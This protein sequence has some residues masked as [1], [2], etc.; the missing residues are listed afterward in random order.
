[1]IGA[2]GSADGAPDGE[3]TESRE[4]PVIEDCV[5]DYLNFPRIAPDP[6]SPISDENLKTLL[7][8]MDH[9]QEELNSGALS[10]AGMRTLILDGLNISN[11]IN[12]IDPPGMRVKFGAP[13]RRDSF[14]ETALFITDPY[15]GRLSGTLFSPLVFGPHP[16]ILAV[17]GHTDTPGD[18]FERIALSDLVEA[19]FVV[20]LLEQRGA[21]ADYWEDR[22]TRRLLRAGHSFLGLRVYESLLGLHLLRAL[23]SVQPDRIG[24]LGHSGGSVVSNLTV[25]L[26][27]GF[28]AYISDHSSNYFNV[29]HSWL[30]DETSPAMHRLHLQINRLESAPTPTLRAPYDYPLGQDKSIRFFKEHLIRVGLP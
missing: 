9:Q 13:L 26:N 3:P 11:L 17:H 10:A 19:G 7:D 16:G 28:G 24:L 6:A 14:T 18:L 22:T 23:P 1:V 5:V 2:F 12:E 29:V 27:E 21:G 4:C 20:L 15:I 8:Q 30:G 25:W